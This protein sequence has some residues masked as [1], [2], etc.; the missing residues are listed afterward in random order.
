[1]NLTN[2]ITGILRNASPYTVRSCGSPSVATLNTLSRAGIAIAHVISIIPRK[3]APT[4]YLLFHNFFVN[5]T[6]LSDLQLNPWKSLLTHRVPKAIVLPRRA[7][8]PI[9]A[10]VNPAVIPYEECDNRHNAYGYSAYPYPAQKIFCQ[11]GFV[12]RSRFFIHKVFAVRL[13]SQSYCRQTVCQ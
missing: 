3:N 7:L 6:G 2:C 13:K 12:C 4:R 11:Y 10:A 1:M 5:T 9:S 8:P